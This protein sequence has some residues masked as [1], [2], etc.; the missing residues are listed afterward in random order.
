MVVDL[1]FTFVSRTHVT[2]LFLIV[3]FL[4]LFAA[5]PLPCS[6]LCVLTTSRSQL[7]AEATLSNE[8]NVSYEVFKRVMSAAR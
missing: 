8:R 1:L 7:I 2:E 3:L 5:L 4:F 6:P